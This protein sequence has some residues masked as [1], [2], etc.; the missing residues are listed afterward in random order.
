MLCYEND[1]VLCSRELEHLVLM[2]KEV[3]FGKAKIYF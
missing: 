2:L 3:G 1:T